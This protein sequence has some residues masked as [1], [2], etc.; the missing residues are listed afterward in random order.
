MSV[1]KKVKLIKWHSS[2]IWKR[3]GF[4]REG[5]YI[6]IDPPRSPHPGVRGAL[7]GGVTSPSKRSCHHLAK[8]PLSLDAFSNQFT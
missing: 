1:N 5:N 8:A 7:L 3:R 4:L 6:F 2:G